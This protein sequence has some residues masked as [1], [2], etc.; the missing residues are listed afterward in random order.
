M[1]KILVCDDDHEIVEAISIYLSGEGVEVLKA[2]D[3][4]EALK[5]MEQTSFFPRS[6]RQVPYTLT[7]DEIWIR[8]G[9]RIDNLFF[10]YPLKSSSIGL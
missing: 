6:M 8:S 1:Q 7:P 9:R 2:Y 4:L 5:V 3:G 10:A